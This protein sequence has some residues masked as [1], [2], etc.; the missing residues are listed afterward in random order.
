MHL[1]TRRLQGRSF[2]I[3]FTQIIH[4]FGHEIPWLEP[5]RALP[6]S[7]NTAYFRDKFLKGLGCREAEDITAFQFV[8]SDRSHEYA[9][10]VLLFTH[11]PEEFKDKNNQAI[12]EQ[13][14]YDHYRYI[15]CLQVRD[16]W[17]GK[18]HAS[19]LMRRVMKTILQANEKVWGVVSN[20]ALLPWYLSHGAVMHS[21]LC[22]DDNLW[23]ISWKQ[24][25]N[26]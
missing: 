6:F 13:L 17:R 12:L 7:T 10:G 11:S 3:Q 1:V 5:L 19:E 24:W 20:P 22:N 25:Q 26:P 21:P 23:I 9:G 8:S 18:G 15:T 14:N 16:V 2:L 4:E